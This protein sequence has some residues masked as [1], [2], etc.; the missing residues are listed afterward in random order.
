[1]RLL[2]RG[3]RVEE[4]LRP[5]HEL[6]ESTAEGGRLFLGQAPAVPPR[7]VPFISEFSLGPLPGLFSQSCGA[8]LFLD[9]PGA[10]KR[11]MAV[12]FGT[13]HLSL[14]PDA[15]ERGFGLR[16]VLN[17]VARSSLRSLDIATLDATTFLKRIQASR[18]ADLEGFG[19][20]V[21]RDLLRLAAGSPRDLTF[22]RTLAG[23]DALTLN[24]KISATGLR[25]KCT[26]ALALYDAED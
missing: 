14:D 26:A 11:T 16:V 1:M 15:F 8:V 20:D 2:R 17:S 4:A 6:V 18:N 19:I 9:V 12:T 25:D 7:W 22:A 23:K 10:A 24:T 21:D 5:G 3:R 13:A